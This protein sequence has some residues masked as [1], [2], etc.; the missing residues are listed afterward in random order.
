MTERLD[1]IDVSG[2]HAGDVIDLSRHEGEMLVAEGLASPAD[3]GRPVFAD[4]QH[5]STARNRSRW[6]AE[7]EIPNLAGRLY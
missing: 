5:V 2:H 6:T 7:T 4:L 3:G 1:G